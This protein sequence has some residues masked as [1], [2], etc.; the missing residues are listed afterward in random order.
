MRLLLDLDPDTTE[1]LVESAVANRRPMPWQAE[2]LLRQSL[3][4]PVPWPHVEVVMVASHD[5]ALVAA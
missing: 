1:R 3:G 2:V 5:S 4:L